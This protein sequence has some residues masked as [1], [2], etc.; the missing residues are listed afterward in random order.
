MFTVRQHV[1]AGF[2]IT[3]VPLLL[4]GIYC[5]RGQWGLGGVEKASVRGYMGT[6]YTSSFSI[7][8]KLL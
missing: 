8:I 7:N 6:L 4:N 2:G 5:N 1:D 3:G